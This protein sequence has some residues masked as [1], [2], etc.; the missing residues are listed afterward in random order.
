M[1]VSHGAFLRQ[2]ESYV[3]IAYST[4]GGDGGGSISYWTDGI[5]PTQAAEETAQLKAA[6]LF[7]LE[8]Y[9]AKGKVWALRGLALLL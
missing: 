7:F 6:A 9:A 3:L 2:F 4:V 1:G 8:T 5:T